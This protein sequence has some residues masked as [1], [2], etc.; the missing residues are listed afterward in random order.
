MNDAHFLALFDRTT[1]FLEGP[2]VE[3]VERIAMQVCGELT[4]TYGSWGPQ[5]PQKLPAGDGSYTS[6][7]SSV[8]AACGSRICCVLRLCSLVYIVEQSLWKLRQSK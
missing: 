6:R 2:L 8:G 5:L 3:I 7:S 4:G 1:I